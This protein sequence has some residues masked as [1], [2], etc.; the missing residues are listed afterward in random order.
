M[1][2]DVS[3]HPAIQAGLIDVELASCFMEAPKPKVARSRLRKPMGAK[4]LTHESNIE[5]LEREE[6]EKKQKQDEKEQKKSA[7]EE[8]TRQRKQEINKQKQMK[9]QERAAKKRQKLLDLDIQKE[10]K[11][12][13]RLAKKRAKQGT[14]KM[15]NKMEVVTPTVICD[16]CEGL[17]NIGAIQCVLCGKSFHDY[18]TDM[19]NGDYV[20]VCFNCKKL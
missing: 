7:R 14:V 17:I 20:L 1:Q 16:L 5:S 18:C 2:R 12:M 4:W 8:K 15:S 10:R 11:L 19:A 3:V 13:I 9:Q 6:K